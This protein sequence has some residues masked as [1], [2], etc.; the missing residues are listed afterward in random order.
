MSDK[1][2]TMPIAFRIAKW[3]GFTFAICYI[4]YG[5]VSIVLGVLD[6]AYA[7]LEVPFLFL[8]LGVL[9]IVVA[10]GFAECR[11]WGWTG[12]VALSGLVILGSLF[13]LGH[14]ESYALILL[15]G[16]AMYALMTPKTKACLR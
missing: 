3:Y 4:L 7:G 1:E 12:L 9:L 13:K 15:S 16:G 5:G 10:Y 11:K 6:R 14:I 2:E 8:M